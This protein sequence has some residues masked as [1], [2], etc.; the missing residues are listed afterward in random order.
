MADRNLRQPW[1]AS[2]VYDMLVDECGA[3]E[4]GRSDLINWMSVQGGAEFRFQGSLGFGGKCWNDRELI[5]VSCYPEDKTPERMEAIGNANARLHKLWVALTEERRQFCPYCQGAWN[6]TL[7]TLT[8]CPR[9]FVE[10]D[11]DYLP[12]GVL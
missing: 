6:G 3:K 7:L 1:I 2:V 12:P 8:V 4:S 10:V 11:A 5:R 9:C